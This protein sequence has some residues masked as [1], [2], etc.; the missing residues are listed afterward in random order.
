MP[1]HGTADIILVYRRFCTIGKSHL[2]TNLSLAEMICSLM[3]EQTRIIDKLPKSE[4][5]DLVYYGFNPYNVVEVVCYICRQPLSPDV[6][7]RWSVIC[8]GH[9]MVRSSRKCKTSLC[10]GKIRSAIPED[11][12]IPFVQDNKNDLSVHSVRNIRND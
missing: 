3:K 4:L 10:K 8:L 11:V 6:H 7:A 5:D 9:Y 2:D 1:L 12:S